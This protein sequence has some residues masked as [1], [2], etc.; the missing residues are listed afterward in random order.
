MTEGEKITYKGIPSFSPEIFKE[1]I[2]LD[3]MKS[4]Q[5]E[6]GIDQLTDEG[7]AQLFR[8][9]PGNRKYIGVVGE[10]QFEVIQ[11]RLEHEY[12]A[13]CRFEALQ[14]HKACWMTGE[15]DKIDAFCQYRPKEI[16]VDKDGNRVYLASSPYVLQMAR[17]N[18]PDVTFHETSEFKV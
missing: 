13:K 8:Q 18:N 16:V 5:L 12:S 1:V 2:N 9:N 4:K 3:P 11:Y 10:L 7:V 6:K 17:S 15:A 14:F